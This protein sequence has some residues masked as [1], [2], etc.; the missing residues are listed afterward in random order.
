M[1]VVAKRSSMTYF[2]DSRDHFSHCVRIVMAEKG[3]KA[4]MVE[5]DPNNIPEELSEI[6]PYNSVPTMLDRD[7]T[8]YEETNI[9]MQYLD[10]RFPHPPLLPVTPVARAKSRQFIY[11]IERDWYP[12]IRIITQSKNKEAVAGAAKELRESLISIAPIFAETPYFM[13]DDFTLV[14]CCLIPI[15]WRLRAMGI[16]LPHTRQV[17]PLHKYMER[18]FKRES[19]QVSLTQFE[20]EMRDDGQKK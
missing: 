3:V 8:L 1:G 6:N 14:D 20:R 17:E 15:L 13:S 7:L 2:S 4:D 18:M 9:M 11:R 16:E 5:V 12:L 19:V 10:E